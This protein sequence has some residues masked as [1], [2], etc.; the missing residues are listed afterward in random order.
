V[1][2]EARIG[3]LARLRLTAATIPRQ[4]PGPRRARR[5]HGLLLALEV[6]FGLEEERAAPLGRLA[7]SPEG[8]TARR[9]R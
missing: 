1:I 8:V 6:A 9:G 5:E 7:G 4:M 2:R 3:V